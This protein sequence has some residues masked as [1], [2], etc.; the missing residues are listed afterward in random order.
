MSKSKDRLEPTREYQRAKWFGMWSVLIESNR[1][2]SRDAARPLHR[3]ELEE[4][5]QLRSR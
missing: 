4:A 1:E 2:A 3:L 5:Y